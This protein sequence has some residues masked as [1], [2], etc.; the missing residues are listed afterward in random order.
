MTL[1]PVLQN[2][3]IDIRHEC[4]RLGIMWASVMTSGSQGISRLHMC[5]DM[6]IF[7]FGRTI[8]IGC[9]I[10]QM[11]TATDQFARKY[12]VDPGS[13]KTHSTASS[14]LVVLKIMLVMGSL[15]RML[16]QMMYFHTVACVGMGCC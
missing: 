16:A 15:H 12:P 5:V 14:N 6:I 1:H 10:G 7:Q 8:L 13:E 11:F 3:C 9:K 2:C 4:A